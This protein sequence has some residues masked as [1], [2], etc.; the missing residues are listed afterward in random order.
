MKNDQPFNESNLDS[1]V[2]RERLLKKL[3]C[4][5]AVLEVACAKVRRSLAGPEPDVERL[6]RIHK[7]LRETLEVCLRARRALEE[8][9][10]VPAELPENLAITMGEPPAKSGEKAPDFASDEEREKF[11]RLAPIAREDLATVDLDELARRL[12]L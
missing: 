2:Y 8:R 10:V 5:I 4:L 6:T 3:N 11:A 12:Q 9:G 7:N 1:P